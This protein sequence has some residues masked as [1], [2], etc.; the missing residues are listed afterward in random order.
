[1]PH[2]Y[3]PGDWVLVKRHRRENLEPRWKGP[4]QVIL[5]TP[6]ALKVDGVSSWVHHTHAKLVGPF[7]DIVEPL[8]AKSAWRV[9]RTPNEN[10]PFKLRLHRSPQ[11][12]DHPENEAKPCNPLHPS[13]WKSG[14]FEHPPSSPPA[15]TLDTTGARGD[16]QPL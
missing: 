9:D 4:F 16:N 13:C 3:R 11:A 15:R 5:T 1:M 7:P 8:A 12:A 6:A 10:N 14:G 2:G